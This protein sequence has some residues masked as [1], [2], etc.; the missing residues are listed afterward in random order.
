MDRESQSLVPH[1]I[2]ITSTKVGPD[3]GPPLARQRHS[4]TN[5]ANRPFV[6]R[7]V[8]VF[9]LPNRPFEAASLARHV[10]VVF[11]PKVSSSLALAGL[12]TFPQIVRIASKLLVDSQ[13]NT[14]YPSA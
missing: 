6:A 14:W 8:F 1:R 5:V 2:W 3:L 4:P 12:N 13:Y 7:Q 11:A 9:F 10:F